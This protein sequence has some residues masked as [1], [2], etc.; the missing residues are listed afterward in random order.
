MIAIF[1]VRFIMVG[2]EVVVPLITSRMRDADAK[3][4]RGSGDAKVTDEKER[5]NLRRILVLV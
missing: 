3:R 2:M 5:D 1:S 4:K